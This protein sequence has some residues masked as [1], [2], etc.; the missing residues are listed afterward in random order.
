M[1]DTDA[2]TPL[3]SEGRPWGA[4]RSPGLSYQ[5]LL[6]TDTRQVPDDP[7]GLPAI[8]LYL[9][10]WDARLEDAREGGEAA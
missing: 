7:W 9:N 2:A 6:D 1:T 8:W 4:A 10:R 5:R 3:D